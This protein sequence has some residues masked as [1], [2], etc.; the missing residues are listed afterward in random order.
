MRA[1]RLLLLPLGIAAI[2]VAYACGGDDAASNAGAADGGGSSTSSSSGG[3]SGTSGGSSSGGNDDGGNTG[4]GCGQA[5]CTGTAG[6]CGTIIDACGQKVECEPCRWTADPVVDG[7]PDHVALAASGANGFVVATATEGVVSFGTKAASG[8]QFERVGPELDADAYD[9]RGDLHLAVA[10]DGTP[11]IVFVHGLPG[12]FRVSAAHKTNGTWTVES[13]GY[14]IAASIA[15]A[16]DGTPYV[17]Y[18]GAV[19]G[20]VGGGFGAVAARRSGGSWSQRSLVS[21]TNSVLDIAVAVA[22]TEARLVWYDSS[23]LAMRHGAGTPGGA[24]FAV[25]DIATNVSSGGTALHVD[26][27]VDGAG[28]SH[29]TY[30]PYRAGPNYAVRDQT[31]SVEPAQGIGAH[32]GPVRIASVS[33]GPIVVAVQD[34]SLDTLRVGFRRQEWSSQLLFASCYS[35]AKM[36]MAVDGAGTAGVLHTCKDEKLQLWTQTGIFPTGY[37]AACSSLGKGLCDPACACPRADDGKCCIW[38]SDGNGRCTGS[39][40][41]CPASWTERYCGNVTV[42]PSHVFACQAA[43]PTVMCTPDAGVGAIEPAACAPLRQ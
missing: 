11:W 2:T 20:Q 15:V 18:V 6:M 31:W 27:L 7:N 22:G 8:W 24:T 39:A 1:A 26:I 10:P 14:G 3:S 34:E 32:R 38:G 9:I 36:D 29:V 25:E 40:S 12:D 4:P 16:S 23:A 13:L 37:G 21:Q 17:G 41:F 35:A 5:A 19:T 43:L 42:D 33:G 30:L 28:K